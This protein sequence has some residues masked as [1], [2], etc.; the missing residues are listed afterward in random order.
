MAPVETLF[1]LLLCY[2]ARVKKIKIHDANVANGMV[3]YMEKALKNKHKRF[4]DQGKTS[5]LL[6]ICRISKAYGWRTLW[7]QHPIASGLTMSTDGHSPD[8]SDQEGLARQLESVARDVEKLKRDKSSVTIEHRFGD[9]LGGCNSPQYHRFYDN[10]STY[11]YQDMS[12]QN[13]YPFHEY[14]YQ[15]RQQVRDR[16]RGAST[17]KRWPK[18]EDTPK[19]AFKDHSKPKVEEKGKL[20]T[21]LTRCFKCN[22]VGY[23]A[24]NFPTKR[25]LVFSEDLNGWIEKSEDDCQEG[26]VDKEDSEDQ[27]IAS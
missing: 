25:T 23:M 4:E 21:N 26:I 6:S 9:N 22:G 11:G 17:Y 18:K 3:V 7:R 14:G 27:E 24:I 12:V 13:S 1:H 15:G 19:V 10:V 8:Q 16:R 20:I 2:R 5:K